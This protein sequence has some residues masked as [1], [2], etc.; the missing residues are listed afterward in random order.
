MNVSYS[1]EDSGWKNQ[2][3]DAEH[4]FCIQKARCHE[5]I[6][7]LQELARK[8]SNN[9]LFSEVWMNESASWEALLAVSIKVSASAVLSWFPWLPTLIETFPSLQVKWNKIIDAKTVYENRDGNYQ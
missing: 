2:P 9:V 4:L 3:F 6:T 8:N 7:H 5:L 1:L